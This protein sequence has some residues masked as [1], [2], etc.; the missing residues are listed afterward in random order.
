MKI[1]IASDERVLCWTQ[2]RLALEMNTFPTR[3]EHFIEMNMLH[4]SHNWGGGRKVQLAIASTFN[5]LSL[6]SILLFNDELNVPA[7]AS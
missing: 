3:D 7:M 1:F 2:T 4:R 5:L 6:N